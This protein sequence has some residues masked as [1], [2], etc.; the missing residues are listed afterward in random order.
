MSSIPPD[1][2]EG[3]DQFIHMAISN[4]PTQLARRGRSLT[5]KRGKGGRSA[6]EAAAFPSN[7]P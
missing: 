2:Y 3:H 4:Q 5:V 7:N 1:N 6:A